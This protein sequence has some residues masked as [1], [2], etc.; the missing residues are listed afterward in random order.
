MRGRSPLEALR[1]EYAL[2]GKQP[3]VQSLG[4]LLHLPVTRSHW[5][6]AKRG[7]FVDAPSA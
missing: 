6:D 3:L 2:I 5:E 7:T 1:C 4:V